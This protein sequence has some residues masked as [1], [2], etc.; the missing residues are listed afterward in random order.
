MAG[1]RLGLGG[2]RSASL[3]N[4]SFTAPNDAKGPLAGE[5]RRYLMP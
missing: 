1:G 5:P 3:A 2:V 4:L